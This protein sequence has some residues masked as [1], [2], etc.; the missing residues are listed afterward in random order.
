M[1]RTIEISSF[2]KIDLHSEDES[3]A[4]Q[5]KV[6]NEADGLYSIHFNIK[7]NKAVSPKPIH[8]R[9]KLPALKVKGVWRCGDIHDK[10]L[11]YD[12]ELDHHRSRISVDAPVLCVFGHSDE[13][14]VSIACS[15]VINLIEMNILLRE[16]DCFLYCH[17]IFFSEPHPAIEHYKAKVRVDV[18]NIQFFKAVQEVSN[19]WASFENLKPCTVPAIAKAPLYSTWYNYHQNLQED[20]LIEECKTAKK[21]GFD[22]IIIDD[23]WQTM[24]TN[25]GYDFTGDWQPDRFPNIK[26]FVEKI[27]QTGMQLG[28]WFSVPFCGKHSKSYQ[29]F[30]GKFLTENHRWA[31]VFDPRYSEV[32]KYLIE[33]YTKA[34]AYWNVDA[35][36]L[37]FI[38]D[39]KVYPETDLTKADGRDYANVNEAVDRLLMDAM[40]SLKT[41]KPNLAIEFRQRYVGPALRKYGN[42]FRAF[43]CPNDPVSN[44]IRITD[45]KLLCGETAVHSDMIIWHKEEVVE[46]AALQLVN[47]IFGVPQ[48][49]VLLN[50]IKTPH[51][52]MV[53]HFINYWKNNAT[54]FMNGQF[55]AFAPLSNYTYLKST[56]KQ[57]AIYAVY[58]DVL[59]SV[60]TSQ[61]EIDILNGKTSTSI[62]LKIAEDTPNYKI[63]TFNCVGELVTEQTKQLHKGFQYFEVPVSGL[64]KMKKI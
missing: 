28:L 14:V 49:S 23:G 52:K 24:D 56:T 27:H 48:I 30:K 58:E 63:S 57:K 3:F 19:W 2:P 13:N 25:R 16:E 20:S 53:E 44:R 33:I 36:K 54:V 43:D 34:V 42:M 15:D 6:E 38:D 26:D 11:R 4:M 62:I 21:L 46:I 45:V 35:L 47:A 10:R 18:R 17:I 1:D 40:K 64:I 12:W 9:F 50:K 37:D 39:F 32:R 60:N 5:T 8:L 41:I 22:L 61:A 55:E 59:V 7:A 29:Q 51:L 31:P